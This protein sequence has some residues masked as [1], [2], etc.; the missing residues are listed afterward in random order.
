MDFLDHSSHYT[1]E[2][3]EPRWVDDDD[4][5][6]DAEH[7][8]A[9]R[10]GSRHDDEIGRLVRSPLLSRLLQEAVRPTLCV[11]ALVRRAPPQRGRPRTHA[12]LVENVAARS[13]APHPLDT[14]VGERCLELCKEQLLVHLTALVG[15][16]VLYPATLLVDLLLEPRDQPLLLEKVG[17]HLPR[18]LA[19]GIV[20][21]LRLL[22]PEGFGVAST[23]LSE[24]VLLFRQLLLEPLE[25]DVLLARQLGS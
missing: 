20:T 4:A 16:Q 9:A 6:S 21:E 13:P 5:V 15:G 19:L 3:E 14:V 18:C 24:L 10:E 12:D 1:G 22:I 25:L 23:L 2:V 17:P 7:L 11:L 8:L